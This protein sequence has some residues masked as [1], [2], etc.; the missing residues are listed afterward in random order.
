M[1]SSNG[2]I[3]F[4]SVI[5]L[6]IAITAMVFMGILLHN[7]T[8]KDL[9]ALERTTDMIEDNITSAADG[10]SDAIDCQQALLDKN[11]TF[12]NCTDVGFAECERLTDM[13]VASAN[14]LTLLTVQSL[15][16]TLKSVVDSCTDS[17]ST[18]RA[19]IAEVALLSGTPAVLLESGVSNVMVDGANALMSAAWE[20][21]RI[22]GLAGSDLVF[23]FLVLL[24]WSSAV[25]TTSANPV[26]TYESLP[27]LSDLTGTRF[28][29]R[30]QQA[31]WAPA[32]NTVVAWGGNLKFYTEAPMGGLFQLLSRMSIQ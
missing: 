29:L 3:L 21:Y 30:P 13:Y 25:S 17:I 19:R 10:V 9:N 5:N 23:E 2:A 7:N 24:P 14:N 11:E 4:G 31:K 15:N 16:E 20:L 6:A 32:G 12:M 8:T 27:F 22:D 28:L 1:T 18:L 26:I